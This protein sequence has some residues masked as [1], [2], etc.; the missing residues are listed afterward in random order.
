MDKLGQFVHVGFDQVGPGGQAR[1]QRRTG[2]VDND[3]DAFVV[4]QFD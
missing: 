3:R 2:A 4:G 1:G